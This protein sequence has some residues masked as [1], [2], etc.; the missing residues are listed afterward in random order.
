MVLV[1]GL[2]QFMQMRVHCDSGTCAG[3][4]ARLCTLWGDYKWMFQYKHE[5]FQSEYGR[6]CMWGGIGLVRECRRVKTSACVC[7]CVCLRCQSSVH[8]AFR[9][10]V[11]QAG[12]AAP[13]L[14]KHFNVLFI[15]GGKASGV[16][17]ST[18]TATAAEISAFSS[19]PDERGNFRFRNNV[20][21]NVR[22]VIHFPQ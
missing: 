16:F 13:F 14:L 2:Q 11:M 3:C 15:R 6:M 19:A 12:Y 4:P 1:S 20:L 10:S 9:E 21:E 18:T 22:P 7:V 5:Y 8:S 17:N